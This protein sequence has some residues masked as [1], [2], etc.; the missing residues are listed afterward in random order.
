[1]IL[2]FSGTGNSAY[3]ANRIACHVDDIC[4][5]LFD[6]I[7]NKDFSPLESTRPFVIVCPTY[8]WQ[9][10]RFL[11]DYLKKVQLIGS[12]EIYYVLTCGSEIGNATSYL[13][14]LSQEKKMHDLGVA[15]IVMPENYIAMFQAPETNEAIAI[16]QKAHQKIDEISEKILHQQ[17]FEAKKNNCA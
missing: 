13:K 16:I 3:V 12:S 2:Y 11:R 6:R 8:G 15:E 14:Q 5:N 17:A 7:K 4:L 10:P 1:M 9:M